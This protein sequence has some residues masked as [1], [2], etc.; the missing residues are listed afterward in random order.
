MASIQ[1]TASGA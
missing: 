1:L